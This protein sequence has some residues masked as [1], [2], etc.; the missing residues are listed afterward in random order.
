MLRTPGT[1]PTWQK[2][3][4]SV[5]PLGGQTQPPVSHPP[6]R[7]PAFSA[8]HRH[9]HTAPQWSTPSDCT[10]PITGSTICDSRRPRT[11]AAS[12]GWP[13]PRGTPTSASGLYTSTT[14]PRSSPRPP[15]FFIAQR[16]RPRP[17]RPPAGPE[18]L[19]TLRA[20]AARLSVV[21]RF[22][23]SWETVAQGPRWWLLVSIGESEASEDGMDPVHP[24]VGVPL[25]VFDLPL[26]QG[27]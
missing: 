26:R 14:P 25:V 11:A 19:V 2:R 10:C 5:A 27:G 9:P 4:P 21:A 16:T 18:Q 23:Q 12:A 20:P 8:R 15:Q 1:R 7:I 3:L 22:H 17:D 13:S 24:V 6:L